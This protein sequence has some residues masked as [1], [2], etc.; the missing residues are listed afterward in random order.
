MYEP[1]S[2]QDNVAQKILW[3]FEIKNIFV[4]KACCPETSFMVY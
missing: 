1:D 4:F 2:A 3:D